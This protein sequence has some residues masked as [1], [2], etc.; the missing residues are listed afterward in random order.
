MKIESADITIDGKK[1]HCEGIYV[2]MYRPASKMYPEPDSVEEI[3]RC[4][5]ENGNEIDLAE[6][7]KFADRVYAEID[8]YLRDLNSDEMAVYMAGDDE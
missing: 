5:D 4:M 7:V 6:N 2:S 8:E 1:Y 3:V